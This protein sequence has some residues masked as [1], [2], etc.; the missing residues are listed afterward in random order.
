MPIIKKNPSA[1]SEV[2]NNIPKV[3]APPVQSVV[4][5]TKYTPVQSLLQYVEGAKWRVT[6]FSQVVDKDNPIQGQD[7]NV[8]PVYQQYKKVNG[9]EVKVSTPLSASQEAT[10]G[11]FTVTG[12]F[13]I[14]AYL[15]AN[16]GDMF[17][18]DVGDGR[19][20]VFEIVSSEQMSILKQ[21]V[22][23]VSYVLK[24]Y[25][26][27]APDRRKDLDIK[28][29]QIYY[30]HRD[31]LN[32]GQNP[33]IIE[34]DHHAVMQ[35]HRK[36]HELV[37]N[38]FIWFF[39]RELGTLLIPG[40]EGIRCYDHFVTGALLGILETGDDPA[41]RNIRRMNVDDDNNLRKPQLF[42]ALLKAD[43]SLL[44]L[45]NRDMGLVSVRTFA[46][47]PMLDGVRYSGFHYVVYPS[48]P[49]VG[50]DDYA[51]KLDW[52]K[53][54]G[55]RDMQDP[56]SSTPGTNLQQ[57][58][59]ADEMVLGELTRR[60]IK[61]VSVYGSYVFSHDFYNATPDQSVLE[62]LTNQ[63]L[64][65]EPVDPKVLLE[66]T[67]TYLNWGGLERFYYI[68]VLLILIKNI[69]RTT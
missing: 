23:N 24:Y 10:N 59:Y 69:I 43:Q 41:I 3:Y 66:L 16:V 45:A 28:S 58:L 11:M 15:K 39:S 63:Y 54:T 7:I 44:R 62:L 60:L 64:K 48:N 31:F 5:D 56:A 57:I 6:Y 13:Y 50:P 36:Y 18:A 20:G 32:H 21:A 14:S 22:Y 29:V 40:Q 49:T 8:S 26:D 61:P 4:V 25:S 47:D 12:S 19:E 34:S 42:D 30:Y 55:F 2:I 33:L 53:F 51:N 37:Q 9:L 65:G 68:P 38:Y 27:E 1:P 67:A 35:L 52:G 46:Y 17:A